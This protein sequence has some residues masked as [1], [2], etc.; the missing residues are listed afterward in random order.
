[1]LNMTEELDP[2]HQK[3]LCNC[4]LVKYYPSKPTSNT[5]KDIHENCESLG[6]EAISR[7]SSSIDV[8]ECFKDRKKNSCTDSLLYHTDNNI[9]K[10]DSERVVFAKTYEEYRNQ[11]DKAQDAYNFFKGHMPAKR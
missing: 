9:G 5:F 7:V 3:Y 6:K 10:S 2:E 1:M 4:R 8:D 11:W